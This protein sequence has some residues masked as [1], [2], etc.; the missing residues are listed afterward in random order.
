[1]QFSRPTKVAWV[2]SKGGEELREQPKTSAN[3]PIVEIPRIK[4][5]ITR[6][7]MCSIAV[8]PPLIV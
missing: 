7:I 6:K 1:M 8:N 3:K 4:F 2:K 5:G